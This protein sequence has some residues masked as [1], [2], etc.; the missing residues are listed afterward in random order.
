MPRVDQLTPQLKKSCDACTKSKVKCVGGNPCNRCSKKRLDCHFSVRKRRQKTVVDMNRVHSG[1]F[2]APYE[3]RIWS[4]FFSLFKHYSTGPSRIQFLAHICRFRHA[5]EHQNPVLYGK[6]STWMERNDISSAA[7]EQEAMNAHA[8]VENHLS[9][10]VKAKVIETE[11]LPVEMNTL[12]PNMP[13]LVV[14]VGT[15]LRKMFTSPDHW[16]VNV[17]PGFTAIFGLREEDFMDQLQRYG[18]GFLPWNVDVLARIIESE[19][20]LLT[21]VQVLAVKNL[22]GPPDVLPLKRSTPSCHLLE[23]KTLDPKSPY[24]TSLVICMHI[25]EFH[26]E[27]AVREVRIKIIPST[28]ADMS[29]E[30]LSMRENEKVDTFPTVRNKRT[31]GGQSIPRITNSSPMTGDF[32]GDALLQ[33]EQIDNSQVTAQQEPD[34]GIFQEMENL[35]LQYPQVENDDTKSGE[36]SGSEGQKEWVDNLLD[37]ANEGW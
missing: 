29:G 1:S 8:F 26:K 25:D 2:L 24:R 20:E 4:V 14:S 21:L 31:R 7:L 16:S 34:Y 27:S 35:N 17:S 23:L 12:D 5:L 37:W 15:T 3:K 18:G 36:I 19:S 22:F 11:G 6:L 9:T 28:L 32:L 33:A 13:T 10:V 30:R